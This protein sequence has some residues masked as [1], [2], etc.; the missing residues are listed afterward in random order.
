MLSL[1]DPPISG[2]IRPEFVAIMKPLDLGKFEPCW[3]TSDVAFMSPEQQ[4][5]YD[6]DL[7]QLSLLSSLDV[8]YDLRV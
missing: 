1:P 8:I 6:H 3:S 7:R 2:E 4:D 5:T